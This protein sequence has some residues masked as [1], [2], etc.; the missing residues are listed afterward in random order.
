MEN[1]DAYEK[2]ART[3]A[4]SNANLSSQIFKIGVLISIDTFKNNA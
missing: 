2:N 4:I 1:G 3:I